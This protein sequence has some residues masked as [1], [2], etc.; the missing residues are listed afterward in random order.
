MLLHDGSSV[1]VQASTLVESIIGNS[2][3]S[4]AIPETSDCVEWF[5]TQLE[6]AGASTK[7]SRTEKEG[8][9]F[10][11]LLVRCEADGSVCKRVRVL[12]RGL[13][14]SAADGAGL[15]KEFAAAPPV[16]LV[17]LGGATCANSARMAGPQVFGGGQRFRNALVKAGAQSL[18]AAKGQGNPPSRVLEVHSELV[19][20][21]KELTKAFESW[22]LLDGGSSAASAPSPPPG[23]STAS[24]PAPAPPAAAAAAAVTAPVA[25]VRVFYSGEMA[26]DVARALAKDLNDKKLA[27]GCEGGSVLVSPLSEF[28]PQLLKPLL[29]S[30]RPQEQA[31]SLFVGLFVVQTV[32]HATAPEDGQAFLR[33]LKRKDH[34]T[35]TAA[36]AAAPALSPLPPLSGLGFAVVGLGDSNLLLDRQ[37]TTAK[38]CNQVAQLVDQRAEE[39]GGIRLC[40]RGEGDERAGTQ[41]L[42]GAVQ[43]WTT[44]VEVELRKRLGLA[45][46]LECGSGVP[47]SETSTD[48]PAATS[49]PTTTTTTT[50][51][52][53]PKLSKPTAPHLKTAHATCAPLFVLSPSTLGPASTPLTLLSLLPRTRSTALAVAV[54]RQRKLRRAVSLCPWSVGRTW[55]EVSR[56]FP[57]RHYHRHRYSS[58][59]DQTTLRRLS[60]RQNRPLLLLLLFQAAVEC[61]LPLPRPFVGQRRSSGWWC[62]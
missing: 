58:K 59:M 41:C 40:A 1:A 19:D 15:S 25:G 29:K 21:P 32:E 54:G 33:W 61:R 49:P 3:T 50:T 47:S 18:V 13:L 36:A 20:L 57:R 38:D 45:E 17:L 23:E 12:A 24:P 56:W 62:R 7:S 10:F 22:G 9:P 34:P 11:M 43:Q 14:K 51:T 35:T 55:G 37:T 44:A 4:V 30:Q 6:E 46:K 27:V 5:R 2:V 26:E 31:K 53:P 8:P 60:Q 42:T 39:L 28:K 52:G 16:H 48:R